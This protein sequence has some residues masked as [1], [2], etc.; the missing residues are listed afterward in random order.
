MSRGE[1]IGQPGAS[2]AQYLS[3]SLPQQA[4]A[5]H[6]AQHL[7]QLVAQPLPQPFLWPLLQ[8]FHS[9]LIKRAVWSP[10]R[11]QVRHERWPVAVASGSA[12]GRPSVT[13][14]SGN[15]EAGSPFCKIYSLAFF[16]AHSQTIHEVNH[17]VN[18]VHARPV[19][20]C[21]ARP[22][23]ARPH[24]F[25]RPQTGD[26]HEDRPRTTGR[27]DGVIEGYGRVCEVRSSRVKLH[28]AAALHTLTR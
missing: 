19:P 26:F 20:C 6:L 1:R 2:H 21:P 23:C 16:H 3:R 27:Q 4:L 22:R 7:A 5:Q 10:S 12:S 24:K 14:C 15:R 28:I 25:T 8:P 17:A 18:T 13:V 9:S 11:A